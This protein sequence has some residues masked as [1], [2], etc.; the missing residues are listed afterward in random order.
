MP[1]SLNVQ[2]GTAS[3][4]GTFSWITVLDVAAR[5]QSNH[6]S[7]ALP[8][9]LVVGFQLRVVRLELVISRLHTLDLRLQLLDLRLQVSYGLRAKNLYPYR[10]NA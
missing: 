6:L 3:L 1:Q 9:V 2:I 5:H 7:R 8:K 10:F 4:K